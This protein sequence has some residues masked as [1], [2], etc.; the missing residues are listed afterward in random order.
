MTR[1]LFLIPHPDDETVAAAATIARR[2]LAG[3]KLFGLYLTCGVPGPEHLWAWD[4]R[5]REARVQQRRQEARDAAAALG[6]EPVGFSDWSSRTLKLHL[7]EA[8][9]WIDRMLTQYEID[10]LWVSA[11]EGGHQDHDVANFLAAHAAGGRPV[12]E[13]AEYSMA[14]G[15]PLWQLFARANGTETVMRLTA[16]EAEA[17]RR[18]LALYRSEKFSLVMVRNE[19]ESFRPLPAY[20]YTRPP[21]AGRLSREAY[22]WAGRFLPHPRVDFEPSDRVYEALRTFKTG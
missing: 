12:K 16:E 5:K 18:L 19:Y 21:H 17:K 15:R 10:E 2:R 7:G 3:D 11:W 14:A 22:H 1:I 8:L 13:F 4:R 9:V 20:D 6:I